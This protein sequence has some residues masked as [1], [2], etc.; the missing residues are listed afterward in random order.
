M[1]PHGTHGT[2]GPC[3]V[4]GGRCREPFQLPTLPS[5]YAFLPPEMIAAVNEANEPEAPTETPAPSRGRRLDDD[6]ARRLDDD[7]AH[8]P[9]ANR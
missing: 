2:D 7:R 5:N 1:T 8:H 4:C 9:E 3:G 6:R